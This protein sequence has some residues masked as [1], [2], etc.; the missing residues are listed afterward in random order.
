MQILFIGS[1]KAIALIAQSNTQQ[2]QPM[3]IKANNKLNIAVIVKTIRL[4]LVN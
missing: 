3:M 1:G 2:M 4:Y